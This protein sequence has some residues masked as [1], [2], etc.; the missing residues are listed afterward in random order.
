MVHDILRLESR[1]VHDIPAQSL[2]WYM[3]PQLEIWYG[4]GYTS[5][6]RMSHS[7]LVYVGMSYDIPVHA[8]G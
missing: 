3:V 1:M 4:I 8:Q 5:T 6:D 2:G 7:I